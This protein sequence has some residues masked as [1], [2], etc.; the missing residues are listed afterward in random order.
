[1]LAITGLAAVLG[2]NWSGILTPFPILTSILAIFTHTLQGS[3]STIMTLRG[4][5]IGVMG[6]TTFLFLQAFL[7][8]ELS[9]AISFGIAFLVNAG[10]NLIANRVW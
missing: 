4:L 2:P 6:F 3:D 10:I 9:V 1:V 5:L 7:L 8:P